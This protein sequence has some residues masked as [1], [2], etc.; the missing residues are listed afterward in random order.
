MR[1]ACACAG[2]S[3]GCRFCDYPQELGL[4][5]LDGHVNISQLQLLSHQHK[6]STRIELFVGVG[7][8]YFHAT[9]QRLGYLSLDSNERSQYKVRRIQQLSTCVRT[10]S[11]T[12]THTRTHTRARENTHTHICRRVS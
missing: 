12:H 11:R 2:K 10:R 4:Q 7:D 8:D 5:F 1:G 9:F 3:A 6:I